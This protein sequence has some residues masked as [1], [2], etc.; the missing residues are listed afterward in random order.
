MREF[1]LILMFASTFIF[2]VKQFAIN[3]ALVFEDKN[4]KK[5]R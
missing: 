4:E 1:L 2:V 3:V 5:G